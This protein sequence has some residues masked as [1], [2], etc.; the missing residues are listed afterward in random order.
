M[1]HQPSIHGFAVRTA[2]MEINHQ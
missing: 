2:E 1:T